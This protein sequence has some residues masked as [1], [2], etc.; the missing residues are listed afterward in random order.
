MVLLG[1]I[2][3]IKDYIKKLKKHGLGDVFF[4]SIFTE[5]ISFVVFVFIVRMFPKDE[6]G[7]YAI[8][9]NIYGYINV[10]VGLGLNNGILQYCSEKRTARQKNAIYSYSLKTGTVFNVILLFFVLILPTFFLDGHPKS[11]LM[12]M[13]A[14]PL[15]TFFSNFFIT[16][17]RIIKDNRHF[18]ISNVVSSVIFVVS[19]ALLSLW[20]GIVGYI[21]AFYI[22]YIS[23]YIISKIFVSK[24]NICTEKEILDKSLKKEIIK[25][26]LVCCLTNFVSQILMLV[27]V[28]C[29]NALIGVPSIVAT[30][31][32][33]TQIPT[34]L[35]FIP[36]S[37]ITFVFPYL[38][39]NNDN[40]IWLKRNSKRII[41][42][43]FAL[44]LVISLVIIVFAPIIVQLLWG[45][46]YMDAV[47]ILRL[48]TLNYLITGTF[49]AV[50]G[51]IM[52]AIKKVNV[53]LVKV[54]ICSAIN[55]GLDV[56]LISYWGSLG[57]A[58]AT[59]IVSVISSAFAVIYFVYWIKKQERER[60]NV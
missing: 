4:S 26:S 59:I 19:A 10:F 55:I 48:L 56:V 54:L 43:V 3:Q 15:F 34:A 27:D 46:K 9:Y 24:K 23:S 31:K 28:T 5:F 45:E 36:S 50:F 18:M 38:A 6:Y 16:R 17:L 33:A 25:Y 13:A 47:P 37:V 30:Y 51:N 40:Y 35:L 14:W 60:K 52:V 12:T 53:N 44:N 42:G 22:K 21:L 39:E 49:N 41:A 11:F 8:A 7:Y 58:Y 57:A 20:L 2:N 29:I 32:A 1:N